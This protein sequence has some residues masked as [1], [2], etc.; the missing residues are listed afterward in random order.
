VSTR[1][2]QNLVDTVLE[3]NPAMAREIERDL[4]RTFPTHSWFGDADSK[5]ALFRVLS[6]YM[7]WN[8]QLGYCQAMNFIAG[9]SISKAPRLTSPIRYAVTCDR[10]RKGVLDVVQDRGRHA[11]GLFLEDDGWFDG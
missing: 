6:S 3:T 10:R 1:T 7:C 4:S 8:P 5:D 9:A 11:Q 2:Y